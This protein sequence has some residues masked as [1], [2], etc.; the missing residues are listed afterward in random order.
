MMRKIFQKV[1][2]QNG[3]NSRSSYIDINNNI[4]Q[5]ITHC[6]STQTS[7]KSSEKSNTLPL[8]TD[9]ERVVEKVKKSGL[10]ILEIWFCLT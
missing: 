2:L 4:K 3:Q 8:K 1:P 5:K 10:R 9:D 6:L 7:L